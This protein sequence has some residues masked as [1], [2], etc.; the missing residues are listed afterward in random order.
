MGEAPEV[1]PRLTWFS[2]VL[3]AALAVVLAPACAACG[4]VLHEP[5]RGAVCPACWQSI[6]ALTPPLCDVCGDPLPTWR[7]RPSDRCARCRRISR[8]VVRARAVGVYDGSLRAILHALKYDGR[9]SLA[10]P[11]AALMRV[12]GAE[13][14]AG[15]TTVVPVPL[16]H[17]KHRE[18]GFNQAADLASHLG[19]PVR[20]ALR[21]TR[22]TP[23]QA[24]LPAAQRHR[25][26][27]G[28]FGPTRAVDALRGGIVLLVDD[29]STTGATLEACARAL[30]DA[31]VAE[32]RALT[33]A[34]A[35]AR[36]P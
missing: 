11:L 16:H 25:N 30:V 15:A 6:P 19:L 9:R 3:D 20:N 13:L 21:R 34:R 33:V 4:T 23:A 28:A 35:V 5:T 32:V 31:G 18:R 8:T 29:V 12:H 36:R 17:S 10:V 14:I 27:R 2:R 24:G 1:R 7:A 22:A 26:V